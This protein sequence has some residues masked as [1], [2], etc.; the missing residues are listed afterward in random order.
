L[1]PFLE[2]VLAK[3]NYI[4]LDLP[5]SWFSWTIPV[6]ENSNAIILTGINTVPCLRQMRA[7]L[8]EVAK[9]K[10]SPSQIAIVMN[11]VKRRLLQRI[12]RRTHVERVFPNEKIYYIHEHA[13]AVERVNTGTPAALAGAHANEYTNLMSFCTRLGQTARREAVR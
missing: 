5:V 6:L 2:M 13:D 7:T 3:Y 10:V 4:I 12:E 9:T 11:R 8:D 1:D